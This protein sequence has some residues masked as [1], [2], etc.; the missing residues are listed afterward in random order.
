MIYSYGEKR[1]F[2]VGYERKDKTSGCSES[3]FNSQRGFFENVIFYF[4][5]LLGIYL[6]CP[7]MLGKKKQ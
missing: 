1:G 3:V 7:E 6:I 4:V 2:P 5:S